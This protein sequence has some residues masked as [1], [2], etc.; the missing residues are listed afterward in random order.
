MTLFPEPCLDPNDPDA[1][2]LTAE[3][4]EDIKLKLEHDGFTCSF[5]SERPMLADLSG[6]EIDALN[7]QRPPYLGAGTLLDAKIFDEY[8]KRVINGWV[9]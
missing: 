8:V 9:D 7:K 6:K 3:E 2:V 5:N 1:C 4:Q